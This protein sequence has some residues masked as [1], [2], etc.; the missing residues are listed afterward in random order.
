MG[1]EC[2]KSKKHDVLDDDDS[3]QENNENFSKE[4]L[5]MS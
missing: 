2:C 3:L 4:R 5:H 1:S